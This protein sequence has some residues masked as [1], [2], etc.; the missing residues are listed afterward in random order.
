MD[1]ISG[2]LR[3]T[4]LTHGKSDEIFLYRPYTCKQIDANHGDL[5]LVKRLFLGYPIGVAGKSQLVYGVG[6][7]WLQANRIKSNITVSEGG[8]PHRAHSYLGDL[9][10]YKIDL[11]GESF[12]L[13]FYFLPWP[14]QFV[15]TIEWAETEKDVV[16]AKVKVT[17]TGLSPDEEHVFKLP[18]GYGCIRKDESSKPLI[19][20]GL[21]I[22]HDGNPNQANFVITAST[23]VDGKGHDW[24]SHR[25]TV[26]ALKGPSSLGTKGHPKK[27]LFVTLTQQKDAETSRMMRTKKV[28]WAPGESNFFNIYNIYENSERCIVEFSNSTLHIDLNFPSVDQRGISNSSQ[29]ITVELLSRW[30]SDTSSY[31]LIDSGKQNED[32]GYKDLILERRYDNI[33]LIQGSKPVSIS[34]VKKLNA[35]SRYLQPGEEKTMTLINDYQS[36]ITIFFFTPRYDRLLRKVVIDMN[37]DHDVDYS[38]LM[39]MANV[40]SCFD[41]DQQKNLVINYPV[42]SLEIFENLLEKKKYIRSQ[43]HLSILS[44]QIPVLPIQVADLQIDLN[45]FSMQVR[46]SLIDVPLT[47]TYKRQ[48]GFGLQSEKQDTSRFLNMLASSAEK[49]ASHC[50]YYDCYHFSYDTVTQVC[51]LGLEEGTK[52]NIKPGSNSNTMFSFVKD[53]RFLFKK[54]PHHLSSDV[55][56]DL[57]RHIIASYNRKQ[58]DGSEP[59]ILKMHKPGLATLP[60][61]GPNYQWFLIPQSVDSELDLFGESSQKIARQRGVNDRIES[62]YSLLY[63]GREFEDLSNSA[64]G[65]TYEECADSCGVFDHQSFSYCSR[66]GRCRTARHHQVGVLENSE[67]ELHCNIYSL[68]YLSKFEKYDDVTVPTRFSQVEKSVKPRDCANMCIEGQ[69]FHCQGFYHCSGLPDDTQDKCFMTDIHIE[70]GS[71]EHNSAIHLSEHDY[72]CDFYSRSYLSHYDVYYGKAIRFA[73]DEPSVDIFGSLGVEERARRCIYTS[74]FAFEVCLDKE[75]PHFRHQ[76]R[77]AFSEMKRGRLVDA[78]GCATFVVSGRSQYKRKIGIDL[79]QSYGSSHLARFCSFLT[80]LSI[81]LVVSIAWKFVLFR[82]RS[83]G[84]RR[85]IMY[86]D[87]SDIRET[88]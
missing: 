24:R 12:Q 73:G 36:S 3:T 75:A 40:G 50:A 21:V 8:D 74:C 20:T 33:S 19:S 84:I 78:K 68:D 55:I 67:P 17:F 58:L 86:E 52:N 27:P 7:L 43:L 79:D 5:K 44:Y 49:C 6:P 48:V 34:V 76:T 87:G 85:T 62:R 1:I 59:L 11:L 47:Q 88:V 66:S 81:G 45:L 64:D 2:E 25:Y 54:L 56:K 22:L 26:D 72:N 16:K 39:D 10:Q 4:F 31:H 53:S 61:T 35:Y 70:D 46:L 30:F 38:Y 13:R 65:L 29:K 71:F 37:S 82:M 77:F 57:L 80:G 14:Y 42:E 23:P 51:C 60:Q 28:W 41:S 18:A 15:D 9:Q 32:G 69:N 63:E 83:D